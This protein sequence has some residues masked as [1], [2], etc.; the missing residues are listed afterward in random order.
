MTRFIHSDVLP[1][2]APT[3][4]TTHIVSASELS[5]SGASILGMLSQPNQ[6]SPFSSDD[7]PALMLV[8]AHRTLFAIS[9]R[10][11]QM[12]GLPT[13]T[14][15][16]KSLDQIA[17]GILSP[18]ALRQNA[19]MSLTLF[20]LPDGSQMFATARS[21][22]GRQQHFL[23]WVIALHHDLASALNEFRAH[24]SAPAPT[25]VALQGQIRNIQELIAMLPRFSQHRYWHQLLLE[26]IDRITGE[27][28]KEV[29][30]LAHI[31]DQP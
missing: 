6:S 14:A 9:A 5:P 30:R 20:D 16:G 11:G 3:N 25:I 15:K 17:E 19:T 22:T 4:T 8:D 12:L 29:Q 21:L 18:I 24:H 7:D 2:D 1:S 31:I 28:E 13:D 10:A 26:H 23:G 27:M